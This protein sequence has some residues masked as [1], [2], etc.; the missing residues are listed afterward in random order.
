LVEELYQNALDQQS[1]NLTR[2]YIDPDIQMIKTQYLA[3][4]ALI[5]AESKEVQED[6]PLT[7]CA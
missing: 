1:I 3:Q 2:A 5:E 4:R 7:L 6:L